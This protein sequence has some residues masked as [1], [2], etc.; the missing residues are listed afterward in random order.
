M[1]QQSTKDMALRR[2]FSF[3]YSVETIL[4]SIGVS[5]LKISVKRVRETTKF[6]TY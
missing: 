4:S 3:S 1:A 5:E 6:M 2:F